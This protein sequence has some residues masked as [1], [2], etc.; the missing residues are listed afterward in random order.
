[1]ELIKIEKE[2]NYFNFETQPSSAY[3]A[4]TAYGSSRHKIASPKVLR[5]TQTI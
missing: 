1:M 2:K 4:G 3:S 5:L